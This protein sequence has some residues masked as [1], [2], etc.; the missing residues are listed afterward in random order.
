[1]IKLDCQYY[2]DYEK[3]SFRGYLVHQECT[4]IDQVLVI[5]PDAFGLSPYFKDLANTFV[6]KRSYQMIECFLNENLKE[7]N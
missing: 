3:I 4:E 2:S 1:M 7:S 5:Y 6:L